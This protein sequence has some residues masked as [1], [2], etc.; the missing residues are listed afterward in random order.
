MELNRKPFQGVYNI[1]RFNWDF[2]L[3]P[4]VLLIVLL[5]FK[6][7]FPEA[8][9]S[10]IFGFVWVAILYML[11]SLFISFYIY[12]LSDLYQFYWLKN[13][14]RKKLLNINAGFD[15]TSAFIRRKFPT[16]QLTICDFYDPVRHTEKSIS[17]ARKA[18]PPSKD[19]IPVP[20]GKLPF[21]DNYFD[22]S[23]T[24]FSAHE[25]RDEQE[26]IS[27]FKELNRVTKF[28]GQILV[29]EHLRDLQNF[30]AYSVGAFHFYSKA[31]WLQ[32]CNEANLLVKDELKITPFISTFILEKNGNSL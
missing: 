4:L 5:F 24:V 16:C 3:V 17:R 15:E 31:S 6:P 13:A 21:S 22:C 30:M 25:I 1:L 32:T 20:T 10:Y 12:D 23:L 29:M 19:S 28:T 26:R 7:L 2:Y 14:H 18:Y 11:S 27:F 9:H 8:I